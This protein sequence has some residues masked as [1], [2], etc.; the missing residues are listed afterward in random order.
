MIAAASPAVSIDPS[1]NDWVRRVLFLPPQ[2]STIA[3]SVDELHYLVI[4]VTMAGAFGVALL[5]LIYTIRYRRGD[6]ETAPREVVSPMPAWLE[7]MIISG[8]FGLFF[9]FWVIGFMQY[10]RIRVPPPDTYDIYVTGKQWMWEFAY[11]EGNHSIAQLYVPA[12]RPVRLLMTSRDV[13]HS[14]FVPDFRLK[15]DVL[16][17]RY[18]TLWFEV[19]EPGRHPVYCAEFCGTNHSTMRAEVIALSNADFARWLEQGARDSGVP[20]PVYQ[21]P[22]VALDLGPSRPMSMARLGQAVAADQGCLRCHT[23]DGTEHIG[24]SFAGLYMATIPLAG[25]RTITADEAYLSESM[26]DPLAKVH[27][28]YS[29]VMP[30]YFGRLQPSEVSAMVQLIKALRDVPGQQPR[31][32]L[33][34]RRPQ[35]PPAGAMGQPP[36]GEELPLLRPVPGGIATPPPAAQGLPPLGARVTPPM[37]G[38]VRV[39]PQGQ[40][41]AE[42]GGGAR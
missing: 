40:E 5:A 21:E 35:P 18:T 6:Q 9:F 3:R 30:S 39:G 14:F 8:I 12:G 25:G 36:W 32:P 24:P 2:A 16:P 34:A 31:Q 23:L 42:P 33:A 11:V 13:I 28:G 1:I 37:E 27:A 7:G 41:G 17:G 10:A 19:K 15:Q 22:S 38:S 4:G 26:M 20:A 29:P